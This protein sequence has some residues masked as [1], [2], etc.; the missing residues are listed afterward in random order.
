[1]AFKTLESKETT[2]GVHVDGEGELRKE[3][4][5]QWMGGEGESARRRGVQEPKEENGPV[6]ILCNRKIYLQ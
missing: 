5:E 3:T 4:T 2:E 6:N 1:M